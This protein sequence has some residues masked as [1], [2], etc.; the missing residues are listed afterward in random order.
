MA[1]GR[2][3]VG[4]QLGSVLQMSLASVASTADSSSGTPHLSVLKVKQ[5]S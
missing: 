3:V 4:K 1:N 5:R 2:N